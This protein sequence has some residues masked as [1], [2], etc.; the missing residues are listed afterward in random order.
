LAKY[1]HDSNE[2]DEIGPSKEDTDDENDAQQNQNKSPL[3][4]EKIKSPIRH[5]KSDHQE[6]KDEMRVDE[7]EDDDGDEVITITKKKWNGIV[8]ELA[9]QQ[10]AIETIQHFCESLKRKNI[11]DLQQNKKRKFDD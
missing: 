4:N 3:R 7:D 9:L 1:S 10:K 2:K 5:E 8:R 11:E 6:Q